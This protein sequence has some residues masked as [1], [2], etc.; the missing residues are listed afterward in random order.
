[1]IPTFPIVEKSEV[2]QVSRKKPI[3]FKDYIYDPDERSG[4]LLGVG[5][6]GRVYKGEARIVKDREEII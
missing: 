4:S 3:Q 1:M 2:R 5:S 6:Y